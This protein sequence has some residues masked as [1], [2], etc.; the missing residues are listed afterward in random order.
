MTDDDL[1]RDEKNPF[2]LMA[3][4]VITGLTSS[5][6]GPYTRWDCLV[7][8]AGR[9][10]ERVTSN[11]SA[12]DAYIKAVAHITAAALEGKTIHSERVRKKRTRLGL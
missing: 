2:Q 11:I 3:D 10:T 6:V 1:T 12:L 5:T 7:T 8:L 9:A 4:G